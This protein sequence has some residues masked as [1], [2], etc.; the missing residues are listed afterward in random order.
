M[1]DSSRKPGGK[2]LSWALVSLFII[3]GAIAI[4]WLA[5]EGLMTL[6]SRNEKP[7]TL[8][9]MYQEAET[10]AAAEAD[11]ASGEAPEGTLPPVVEVPQVSGQTGETGTDA[12]GSSGSDRAS[13]F[14][15]PP[16]VNGNLVIKPVTEQA[17]GTIEAQAEE[18]ASDISAQAG[19][20]GE[21]TE[22]KAAEETGLQQTQQ[23]VQA[24]PGLYKVRV[25][26]YQTRSEAAQA[27][28]ELVK[29]SLP[30]L[31]T[32][33]D[34]YYVQIGAFSNKSNAENLKKRIESLGF[35]VSVF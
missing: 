2:V 8:E 9:E 32:M 13:P 35:P 21:T 4:G 1:D 25:G 7:V 16:W 15:S 29:L 34:Q 30:T 3:A 12:Q 20:P 19:E 14:Q 28:G 11:K 22:E 5:G 31:I 26:P 33:T 10:E 23:A 6:M 18:P 27:A 17:V 24:V